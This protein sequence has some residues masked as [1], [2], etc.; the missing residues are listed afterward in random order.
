MN[1]KRVLVTGGAGFIG[2]NLANHLA[3]DND[4]VVVDDGYLGTPEN[5]DETIDFHEKSVLDDDLPT[6]V[7]VV[8]HLAALS[9]YAMHEDDPTKGARVN[10]EGFVNTV[11][12]A[13]DDGCNT[14]VYA[15]TSSIYGNQT[16]PSPEEM[17]VA[18][19]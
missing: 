3:D 13:R 18:V 4:V 14:V 17:D 2:S 8:F 5:L 1:G 19:N 10:V 6:E 15:S 7:D 16:D 12:Q 9:S 11:E